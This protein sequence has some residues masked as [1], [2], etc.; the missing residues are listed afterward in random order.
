[1]TEPLVYSGHY[2][3]I[4]KVKRRGYS[5]LSVSWELSEQTICC[6]QNVS[7]TSYITSQYFLPLHFAS[8]GSEGDHWEPLLHV[9]SREAPLLR[10]FSNA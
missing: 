3:V 4:I 7:Y 10:E 8:A 5:R 2:F 9:Y 1:M 6:Q